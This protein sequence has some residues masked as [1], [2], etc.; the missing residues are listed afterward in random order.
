[1]NI[2]VQ[3]AKSGVADQLT[4]D[5]V[6]P[7]QINVGEEF[8]DTPF[9]KRDF[10]IIAYTIVLIALRNGNVWSPFT[11]L[12][13]TRLSRHKVSWQEE[14][15]LDLMYKKGFLKKGNHYYCIT[16][17]FLSALSKFVQS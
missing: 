3:N 2:L 7:S 6:K 8:Y 5:T 13:Y 10:E 9:R 16:D 17:S 4:V 11:F 15:I 1:M 14:T 12:D